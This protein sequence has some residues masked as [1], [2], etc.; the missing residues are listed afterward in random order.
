MPGA[1]FSTPGPGGSYILDFLYSHPAGDSLTPLAPG[2]VARLRAELSALDELF[3]QAALELGAMRLGR[4]RALV[5]PLG[6]T[7]S[8]FRAYARGEM[9]S[10]ERSMRCFT[11][12]DT[13][14]ASLALPGIAAAVAWGAA[15]YW[16]AG[17]CLG[18][19]R[20]GGGGRRQ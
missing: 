10:A 9:E 1:S 4:A 6:L 11:L 16:V 18:S 17:R 19:G 14:R 12:A 7:A 8:A 2:T 20:V 15:A 3:A 13:P 5:G